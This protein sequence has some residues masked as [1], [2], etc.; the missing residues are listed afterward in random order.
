MDAGRQADVRV[1]FCEGN[2]G[3]IGGTMTQGQD[4]FRWRNCRDLQGPAGNLK[5]HFNTITHYKRPATT[6]PQAYDSIVQPSLQHKIKIDVWKEPM[7]QLRFWQRRGPQSAL[8]DNM[9][10]K[11]RV[12]VSVD[13]EGQYHTRNMMFHTCRD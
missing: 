2:A 3:N 12:V 10:N 4:C 8:K 5:Q 6:Q 7:Q 13:V 11:N 1:W 9:N